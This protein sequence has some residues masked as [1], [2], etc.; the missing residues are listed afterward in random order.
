[1]RLIDD[2]PAAFITIC[3]V[4]LYT[5]IGVEAAMLVSGS[6]AVMWVTFGVILLVAAGICAWML[7]LLSDGAD[8]PVGSRAP[9]IADAPAPAPTRASPQPVVRVIPT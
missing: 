3:F 2:S 8:A 5:V 6:L 9:S 1:M 7:R 4:V